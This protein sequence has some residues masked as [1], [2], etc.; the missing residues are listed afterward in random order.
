[1]RLKQVTIQRYKC[2]AN[3]R[4]EF[5]SAEPDFSAHLLAGLNG[6]GKSCFLEALGHIFTSLLQ[7]QPAGFPYELEY[8]TGEG[9]RVRVVSNG[10]RLQVWINDQKAENNVV[11]L[12]CKPRRIVACCAGANQQLGDVLLS[13]PREALA[14]ELYALT[15]S[16]SDQP[17]TDA[18]PGI[19]KFYAMLDTDPRVLF[20]DAGLSR[21]VLPVLFAVA[22]EDDPVYAAL[23]DSC[24]RQTGKRI[25]PVAFS[26]TVDDDKLSEQLQQYR[27]R[28]QFGR[29][30]RMLRSSGGKPPLAERVIKRD[31]PSGGGLEL[32]GLFPY[33]T[34]AEGG[35][36]HPALTE[37]YAGDPLMLL[38]VLLAAMQAGVLRDVQ[39]AFQMDGCPDLVGMEALSDGELMWIARMGLVLMSRT[40]TGDSLFLFDEPD[41]HFNDDWNRHFMASLRRLTRSADGPNRQEFLIAT[42]S[43]LLMTDAYPQQIHLFSHTPG[44][45]TAVSPA[46]IPVFAAQHENIAQELFG[47]DAIGDYSRS[48][49]EQALQADSLDRLVPLLHKMGPGYSRFQLLE[50]YYELKKPPEERG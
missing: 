14:N 9:T 6:S 22:P 39:F 25:Q 44:G 13:F 33:H 17:I 35:F 3:T 37:E 47:A 15:R 32:T 10:D 26:L 40:G 30:A 45:G 12:S 36:R 23:L 34:T 41:I 48:V 50:R 11:P 27:H 19:L 8:T 21:L 16:Q 49:V 7:D 29:L 43:I 1:M 18:A 31:I 5:Q 24:I 46:P 4:A 20:L 2:L 38:S 42:H 28:P